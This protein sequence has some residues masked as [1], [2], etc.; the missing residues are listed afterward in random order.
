MTKD[1]YDFSDTSDL[2]ED[3]AAK[4]TAAG[5]AENPSIQKIVDL[6]NGAPRA[7]SMAE[8]IA[9]A[10]R[11]GIELPADTTVRSWIVKA[12]EAG[13][14]ARPTRQTYG[15]ITEAVE[16]PVAEEAVAETA[17]VAAADLSDDPLAGLE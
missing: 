10:T 12:A 4:L 16:A 8:I 17:V 7:L 11:A 14:I 3:V 13:R 9:V 6:V 15:P 2:P 1:L 5:A